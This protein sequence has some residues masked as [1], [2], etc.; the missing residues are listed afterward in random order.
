MHPKFRQADE[1]S[2]VVIGGAIEVHREMGP[3]LIESIYERCLM[4][5][6][7]LRGLR[8]VRQRHVQVKYKDFTFDEDL[9]FDLLIEDCLLIEAKSVQAVLPVHKA[10]TLSYMKLLNV[11]VGLLFNFHELK[12]TDGLHRLL[13]P[14]ANLD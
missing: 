9:R 5:E 2:G 3:G 6:L 7:A 4:H 10:Q 14:G 13:L 12:L 1:L 11:P 8:S